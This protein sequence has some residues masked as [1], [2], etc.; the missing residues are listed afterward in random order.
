VREYV[1]AREALKRR[2]RLRP[3]GKRFVPSKT[4]RGGHITDEN[5]V[6]IPADWTLK[7]LRDQMIIEPL[8]VVQ[9]RILV[10]PPQEKTLRGRVLAVGPGH[11]PTQYDHWDKKKRTK[12]WAGMA[13]VPAQTKIGDIVRLEGF[14]SEGFFWGDKYCVHARE[15]DVAAVEDD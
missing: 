1:S 3:K 7:P 2:S 12:C 13:F 10:L 15:E 8:D 6:F 11:Y 14:N 4:E 9:S 5:L